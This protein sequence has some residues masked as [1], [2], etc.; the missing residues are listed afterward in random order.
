MKQYLIDLYSTS[1]Q[2]ALVADGRP[3]SLRDH[4]AASRRVVLH[5][6]QCEHHAGGHGADAQ[7]AHGPAVVGREGVFQLAVGA[8]GTFLRHLVVDIN[9]YICLSS[10]I[11]IYISY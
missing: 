1:R 3:L 2:E 5:G 7:R 11:P 6:D 4:A 10:D 9:I 8:R